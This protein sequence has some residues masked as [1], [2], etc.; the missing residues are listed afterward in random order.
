MRILMLAP[1][2]VYTP[3]GTPIAVLNRCRALTA[4]GQQVDLVTYPLG[5]DVAVPG[6]RWVRTPRLPG[7]RR[8]KIGPS[9]AKLPL[10][11]LLLWEAGRQLRRGRYDVIH[12]VEEAGVAGWLLRV[13]FRVPYVHDVHSDMGTV[14]RDYGFGPRHPVTLLA[15]WLERRILAGAKVIIVNV[16]GSMPL[17]TAQAPGKQVHLITCW[18][19][20]YR[21]DPAL[22]AKLRSNWGDDRPVILYTGSFEPYQGLPLLLEA[23]ALVQDALPQAR[24]VLVG[25]RPEQVADVKQ[26]AA[27]LGIA[28]SIICTGLLPSDEIASCL[29][30]ADVLVS[31]RREGINTPY[32]IYEYLRAGKPIVATRTA[33]HLDVLNDQCA[34]L[35]QPTPR[36]FAAALL[37]VL[38]DPA[39]ADR[40]SQAAT[41]RAGDFG[42]GTFL[43]QTAAAYQELGVPAPSVPTVQTLMESVGEAG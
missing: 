14:L 9:L 23:M 41:E 16:P 22:S 37:A 32:K 10:D 18:P 27:R 6:L 2:P 19:L 7:L 36:A 26:R 3:R 42:I 8:V 20:G 28:E 34:A 40:L 35:T 15:R 31:S 30:A 33:S 43:Q 13:I 1:E 38:T 25:G 11:A 24:L 39:L 17:V 4:L 12:T 21:V 5:Q 29:A